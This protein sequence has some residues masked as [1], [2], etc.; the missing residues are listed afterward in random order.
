MKTGQN[1]PQGNQSPRESPPIIVLGKKE[2]PKFQSE[3]EEVETRFEEA[4]HWLG[5][6]MEMRE[7]RAHVW[8]QDKQDQGSQVAPQVAKDPHAIQLYIY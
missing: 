1:R 2:K 6:R 8:C 3:D 5:I 7:I 4:L